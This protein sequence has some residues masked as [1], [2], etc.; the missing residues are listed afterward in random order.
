MGYSFDTS[1]I[2]E[3]WR[4]SYP[5]DLFPSLWAK[6]EQSIDDGI[7]VAS[8]EVMEDLGKKADDVLA[9]AK[10]RR[11]MFQPL[12]EDIQKAAS[13][14]LMEF[15]RLVDSRTDRSRADPFVIALAKV[16]N[17]R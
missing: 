14:I 7:L 8:E 2:L 3:G 4:R 16:E 11:R 10:E 15:E 6:I 1:A 9:W 12:T 5:P 13:E 17:L